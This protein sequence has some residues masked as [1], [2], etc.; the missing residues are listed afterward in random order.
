MKKMKKI[1]TLALALLMLLS[2][3]APVFADE[4]QNEDHTNHSI[5]IDNDQDGYTYAA[6]QIFTGNVTT[7]GLLEGKITW[8]SAFNQKVDDAWVN[9]GDAY[10]AA[11]L[12]LMNDL[13]TI[14]DESIAADAAN[15]LAQYPF[16]ETETAEQVALKLTAYPTKDNPIAIA[17]AD[18]VS[19]HVKYAADTVATRSG[20]SYTLT[21]LSDGYYL[22]M[23]TANGVAAENGQY[24]RYILHVVA[25]V[26]VA[27]KGSFPKVDKEIVGGTTTSGD[28]ASGKGPTSEAYIGEYVEYEIVGTLPTDIAFY[29]EYYYVFQDTLSKGLT[30]DKT[31]VKVTVN[32]KDVTKYFYKSEAVAYTGTD[33]KYQGGHTITIG[34][35]DLLALELLTDENGDPVV[36]EIT[37]DSL[38]VL[39]Y[40]AMLNQDAVVGGYVGNPNKVYLEYDNNPNN[41]GGG[42]TNPPPENPEEPVPGDVPGITPEDEVTTFTTRLVVQKVDGTGHILSGAKFQLTSADKVFTTV[43]IVDHKFILDENGTYYE[44]NDG[45]YTQV[46]PV[47][48]DPETPNNESTAGFYVKPDGTEMYKLIAE[49][50]VENHNPAIAYEVEVEVDENGMLAFVGL[51]AGTYTLTETK[52]PVGYE[53]NIIDPITFEIKFDYDGVQGRY[54]FYTDSSEFSRLGDA[55]SLYIEIENLFGG[56]LPSTGGV[57]T[58]MFYIFGGIMFVGAAILLITKKRMGTI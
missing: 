23:N 25:D 29:D 38:V 53:N 13:K 4:L 41:D 43:V 48:D 30:Y 15:P 46:A 7:G 22:V 55:N 47:E 14:K 5:V 10:D 33:A 57:G 39:T 54:E 9:T 58:T 16:A 12:A 8:G 44:L 50:K 27:H 51:G 21:G 36:G 19:K 2:L 40:K 24:T 56:T 17:F 31:S 3:A 45:T 37:K 42:A 11:I 49:P 26:R 6:Y 1:V 20:D 28:T 34:I 32:G 35:Q 18:V 52:A